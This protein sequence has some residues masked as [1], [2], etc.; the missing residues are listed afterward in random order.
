VE[1]LLGHCPEGCQVLVITIDSRAP[2][3]LR[4]FHY[5]M[6]STER[7]KMTYKEQLPATSAGSQGLVCGLRLVVEPRRPGSGAGLGSLVL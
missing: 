7:C 1:V 5:S 2:L 4:G 3:G 6:E